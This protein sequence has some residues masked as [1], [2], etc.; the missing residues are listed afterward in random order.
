MAGTAA[1][2]STP[3]TG[4]V[5]LEGILWGTQWDS[6]ATGD[7]KT[8]ICYYIAG[9]T[10]SETITLDNNQVTASSPVYFQELMAITSAMQAFSN[11]CNV[12]FLSVASQSAADVIWASVNDTDAD[13]A[14]GWANP[15]GTEH[16]TTYNDFQSLIAINYEAYDPNHPDPDLI[17]PGG[18]DYITFIH[19]FGHAMGLAHPHDTGGSSTVFPGVTG[20]FGSYGNF[21]M[22]QGVFTMMSYND[23][24][25]TAPQGQTTDPRYGYELTPMAFDI[26]ALQFMYGANTSYHA[27]DDVYALPVADQVGTGYACIWDAGGTD[28]MVGG[29][30]GNTIDLRAATLQAAV[31]G[32]GWVSSAKGVHGGFTIAN[33]VVIENATGGYG[34]DSIRGNSASNLLVGLGGSDTLN[35]DGGADTLDGGMGNDTC[36]VDNAADQVVE[37]AGGGTDTVTA[38]VTYILGPG[39]EAELLRT[40]SNGG[41]VAIDLTGNT[42]KQTIMGNAG[43]NVLHDGGVGAADILQGLGGN[44]TYR[45]FNAGDTIVEQASEG[46]YDIVMAAVDY[47]LTA[48]AYIE[49]LATN[50]TAGTSAID[51]TGNERH[52]EVVGNSGAN[53][54]DGEAGSDVVKGL[55]GNDI[56]TGGTGKDN[57]VFNAALSNTTNVDTITDFN[58]AADTIQLDN[59]YFAALTTTGPLA[60]SAFKDIAAAPKDVSDRIIYNSDTGGL[61]YDADG[62]NGAFSNVKFASVAT[63]L[64]LTAADFVVI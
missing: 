19:E 12:Q 10:G 32:G 45:V 41:T 39:V 51:L 48:G 3:N 43:V 14:L 15:P 57:F 4:N 28:R 61:Y 38:N 63:G 23:G 59:A 26:A 34:V 42:L 20:P 13:G 2:I 44:D 52:Q 33:G 64:A 27:G 36:Y 1:P 22:N 11:V 17:A 24:W 60:A 35:G 62:S 6:G 25:Q 30:G 56:L 29:D 5:W 7:A 58:V 55:G 54:L 16:S 18:F 21:D 40:T 49:R 9:L 31:G 47:V 50:G 53:R 46:I 37:A 8:Q